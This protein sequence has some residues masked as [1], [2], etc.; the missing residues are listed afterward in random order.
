MRCL[1]ELGYNLFI[2]GR[3]RKLRGVRCRRTDDVEHQGKVGLNSYSRECIGHVRVFVPANVR[4][5]ES[6]SGETVVPTREPC[7][8]DEFG[9]VR[10][11]G[12]KLT[13]RSSCIGLRARLTRTILQTLCDRKQERNSQES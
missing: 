6:M 13:R 10:T 1:N 8:L 7:R 4:N 5:V 11:W 3:D 2:L 9:C 12:R